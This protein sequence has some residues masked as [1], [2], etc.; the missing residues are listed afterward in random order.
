MEKDI[1]QDLCISHDENQTADDTDGSASV[2]KDNTMEMIFSTASTS[3]VENGAASPGDAETEEAIV[4]LLQSGESI[5]PRSPSGQPLP[6]QEASVPVESSAPIVPKTFLYQPQ[7]ILDILET[8]KRVGF[9]AYLEVVPIHHKRYHIQL[10]SNE[11][12]FPFA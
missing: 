5:S 9:S 8:M 3:N 4:R 7:E 10:Q 12:A 6:V 11:S 1:T 2:S